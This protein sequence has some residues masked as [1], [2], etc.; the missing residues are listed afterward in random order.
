MKALNL[1]ACLACIMVM[2][3]PLVKADGDVRMNLQNAPKSFRTEC[4]SCHIAF[5]ASL[6][7][8]NDWQRV[9]QTLDKHYGSDATVT[10]QEAKEI[11][12]YLTA[13]ASTRNKHI[14]QMDPPRITKA[15]WFEREHR[16]IPAAAWSDLRIKSASN[17]AACHTQAAN[18][19]YSEREIS[20]PGYPGKRW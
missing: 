10:P 18:G 20:V 5:P 19:S 2:T 3:A 9:M 8:A 17:C 4:V 16:K 12:Q 11:S 13:N 15:A 7:S 1:K 6:L 14:S